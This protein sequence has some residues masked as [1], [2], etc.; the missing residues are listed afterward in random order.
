[1]QNVLF[2]MDDD[3]MAR[4][5]SALIASDN[6][7][8]IRQEVNYL[9]FAFVA[10]LGA[11]DYQICHEKKSQALDCRLCMRLAAFI[12]CRPLHTKHA[13]NMHPGANANGCF[14]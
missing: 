14:K 8:A 10:P 4:I 13:G 3:R 7:E 2:S 12:A 5:V 6:I 9:T 1:M 11:Y